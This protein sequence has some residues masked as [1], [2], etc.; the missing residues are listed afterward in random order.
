MANLAKLFAQ[1]LAFIGPA[2][3]ELPKDLQLKAGDQIVAIGDS[4]TQGG[5]YLRDVDAVL[6][7]QYPDLKLPKIINVGISGQ[8]AEDLIIRFDKDVVAKK[9]QWVTISIGI[10]DVWHRLKD[11][12]KDEVL[13]KYKENVTKMVEKAQAANIRVVL[14]APT[15]IMEDASAEGNKRLLAYIAAEKEIAADKKCEFVN[16]HEMFV[17]A[18]ESKPEDFKKQNKNWLTGD[19]VHMQPLGDALMALGITRALGIPDS[20]LTAAAK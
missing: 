19:G 1:L 3:A 12:A 20:K 18:L 4:I 2:P 15:L 17:K 11:P 10:N 14:L 8:K 16:L 7:E 5:G 13:A 9:P 6:A